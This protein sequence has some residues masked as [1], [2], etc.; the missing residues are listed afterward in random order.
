MATGRPRELTVYY[1]GREQR[2]PVSIRQRPLAYLLE[3][4]QL[5]AANTLLSLGI[6]VKRLWSAA[7]IPAEQMRLVQD[8]REPEPYEGV[9]RRHVRVEIDSKLLAVQPGAFIVPMDQPLANLAIE[10]LE[11]DGTD[12]F[13]CFGLIR[14][15]YQRR[16]PIYR[17]T[18]PRALSGLRFE[19]FHESL[20]PS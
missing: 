5:E 1:T 7:V 17:L 12:S 6:E 11:P 4:H 16:L 15:G 10:A 2:L 19:V 3:G 18:D 13:V 14:P 20:P 8:D 9:Y